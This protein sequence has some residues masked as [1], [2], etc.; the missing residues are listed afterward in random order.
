MNH[1][2]S[3]TKYKKTYSVSPKHCVCDLQFNWCFKRF[4]IICII[5]NNVEN[6]LE[7][8]LLLVKLQATAYNF[9]TESNSPLWVLPTFFE[10]YKWYQIAQSVSINL[11]KEGTKKNIK[12]LP[13]TMFDFVF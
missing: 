4:D 11:L 7:G 2:N 6:T 9:T 5:L 3:L 10:L 13:V 12:F 1:N 8:V